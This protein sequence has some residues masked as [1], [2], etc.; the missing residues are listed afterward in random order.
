LQGLLLKVAEA[1]IVVHEADDPDA[2]IG[3]LYSKLSKAH[4][5]RVCSDT[6]NCMPYA[7]SITHNVVATK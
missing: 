7:F 5:P 2:F 1:Q 4:T 3:C 6:G